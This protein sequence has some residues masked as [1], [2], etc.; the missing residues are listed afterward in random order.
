[1]K[2][3]TGLI[4]ILI[5]GFVIYLLAS[6]SE[7]LPILKAGAAQD[8]ALSERSKLNMPSIPFVGEKISYSIKKFGIRAGEATL[9][10]NGLAKLD[11]EDVYLA[12]LTVT[13][14]NFR[15]EEKIYLDPE[16]FY[17]LMVKRD[18]NLWGKEEAIVEDYSFQDN[19]AKITK[20]AG[21]EIT[22]Q[23]ISQAKPLDNIYCFIYRYRLHGSFQIGETVAL[24]L[25]TVSVNV[26][27]DEKTI[28]KAAGKDFD[29]YF[30]N[31]D[32]GQYR[33]WFD[34]SSKKIPLRIDAASK[35]G[36]TSMIMTGYEE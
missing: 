18:L 24:Q 21:G 34:A 20:T 17:P 25:P 33:V 14:F 30:L 22:E 4:L 12:V 19:S 23:N 31:S 32:D 9:V 26:H 6:H 16:T 1:M 8:S 7:I 10:F 28:L 36:K 35:F 5:C 2:K 27:I 15:D 29:A 3:V 13:A 11:D